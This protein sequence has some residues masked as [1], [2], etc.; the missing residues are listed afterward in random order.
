MD[1]KID[2][3]SEQDDGHHLRHDVELADRYGHDANGPEN[4]DEQVAH[5]KE[6]GDPH[7][8]GNDEQNQYGYHSDQAGRTQTLLGIDHFIMSDRNKTG[9]TRGDTRIVFHEIIQHGLNC[10]STLDHE[11]H[12]HDGKI[13]NC[14]QDQRLPVVR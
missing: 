13:G 11:V 4:A 3:Q 12:V 1:R 10:F 14:V 8:E 2:S 5:G 9:H 7:A 6:R